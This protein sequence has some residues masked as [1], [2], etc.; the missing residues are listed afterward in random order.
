VTVTTP[1][2]AAPYL[3]E[4]EPLRSAEQAAM[5]MLTEKL[6]VLHHARDHVRGVVV[7]LSRAGL[8]VDREYTARMDAIQRSEIQRL[9]KVA[10]DW[11]ARYQAEIDRHLPPPPN[12]TVVP[13]G[14]SMPKAAAELL[15]CAE[16]HGWVS[17]TTWF[18]RD[19]APTVT[20][21]LAHKT[22]DGRAWKFSH[23]M[24]GAPSIGAS[25][26][27]SGRG[28][29]STPEHQAWHDASSLK[30]IRELI[31]ANPA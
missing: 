17:L 18:V 12:P 7:L 31:A 11:Q 30:R 4:D 15:A 28:L 21:Q 13:D 6:W 2:D 8:L 14:C 26:S 27:L 22:A 5:A 29:Q 20:V 1:A 19:G 23:L 3:H 24:W 25:M 10:E 9:T 16:E